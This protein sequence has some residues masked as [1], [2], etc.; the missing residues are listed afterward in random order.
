MV[1]TVLNTLL[2][3][4]VS[5]ASAAAFC[6]QAVHADTEYHSASNISDMFVLASS[7]GE[8]V[9]VDFDM[10]VEYA[11]GKNVYV[12]DENDNATLLYGENNYHGGD[13]IPSG[14]LAERNDFGNRVSYSGHFPIATSTTVFSIPVVSEVME[15][16]INR[17]V[18]IASVS[19]DSATP[20]GSR[21]VFC[22]KTEM[23]EVITFRNIF[24]LGSVA[25]GLYN[26]T[27]AV[28]VN[29][30]EIELYPTDFVR[31]NEEN[32]TVAAPVISPRNVSFMDYIDV[33]ITCATEDAVIYYTLDG[34]TPDE[35][36]KRYTKSLRLTDDAYMKAVAYAKGMD[37]SKIVSS[38]FM[39]NQRPSISN[40]EYVAPFDFSDE[41][42]LSQLGLEMP[43]SGDFLLDGRNISTGEITIN[44]TKSYGG[45]SPYL[46]QA[47][48]G[49]SLH[50]APGN[51]L[52]VIP[53]SDS[54]YIYSI[55]DITFRGKNITGIL[56]RNLPLTSDKWCS[57][58]DKGVSTRIVFD[59][60]SDVELEMIEVTYL[61]IEENSG[62][63]EIK[64]LESESNQTVVKYYNLSGV[65][66]ENPVPGVYIREN[67]GHREKV[68]VR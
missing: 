53:N 37:R 27:A 28:G 46:S 35:K 31:L 45:K 15:S 40:D 51:Q 67:S 61:K 22:G 42:G 55:T 48:D 1:I 33:T 3:Y 25:P 20:T 62:P 5:V 29:D 64:T 21:I 63:S 44:L 34:K 47:A 23:E 9:Y 16:D 24:S 41:T 54:D 58:E 39:R 11:H 12:V 49:F 50:L 32:I 4:I 36:S 30:G 19:L 52:T 7:N 65:Q 18:C 60:D 43:E 68:L 66:I 38:V 57:E 56:Y 17:M 26:I 2:R 6:C 8:C 59:I 10:T 13:V 14:W